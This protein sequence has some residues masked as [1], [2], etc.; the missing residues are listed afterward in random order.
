MEMPFVAGA[1]GEAHLAL[2]ENKLT[3]RQLHRKDD[4]SCF[5]TVFAPATCFD[6]HKADLTQQKEE[7]AFTQ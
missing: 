1:V 7:M 3:A 2:V 5:F 4:I 6:S